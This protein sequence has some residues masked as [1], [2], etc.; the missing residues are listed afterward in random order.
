[1]W[2]H[3]GIGRYIREFVRALARE[4][5]EKRYGLVLPRACEDPPREPNLFSEYSRSGIYGLREQFEMPRRAGKFDLFHV[6]HFNIPVF[7]RGRMVVTVHDLIYLRNPGGFYSPAAQAYARF[8]LGLL[9]KKEC[10]I[11]SVSNHTKAELLECFPKIRPERIVVIPEAASPFFKKMEDRGI[12]EA[13]RRRES[14]ERPFLLFVGSFKKHKNI[15]LLLHAMQRLRDK[16]FP[17]ELALVGEPDPKNKG[18]LGQITGAPFARMLGRRSDEELRLLYNLAEALVVPSL[19]EGF[20]LPVLEAMGC[21]LP[22][23]VSRTA[24]L[25]EVAGEAGAYFDPR[26]VDALEGVL[27]NI[28]KNTELRNAMSRKG[29]EQAQEFSWVRTARR[30]ADVYERAIASN[31]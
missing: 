20:G 22:V 23:V 15:P 2:G 11:I 21:G 1:M 7:F 13:F 3:P 25:P 24:S 14:L 12:P 19:D 10:L 31:L 28:L 5:P 26:N 30:T 29:I 27:Y 18:L 9:A 6:P 4:F 17:H 16:G 8:F